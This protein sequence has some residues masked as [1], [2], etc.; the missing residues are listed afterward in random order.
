MSARQTGFLLMEWVMAALMGL[1]LMSTWV[2][3]LQ[4]TQRLTQRVDPV[5][6]ASQQ[7]AWL[8]DRLRQV[9]ARAG[10][11]GIDPWARDAPVGLSRRPDVLWL[12]FLAADAD[13]DCE[14][15]RVVRDAWVVERLF[16]KPATSTQPA[17]LSCDAGRCTPQACTDL[18][19]AGVVWL[20]DVTAWGVRW[21]WQTPAG[22][23]QFKSEVPDPT[24]PQAPQAVRIRWQLETGQ[25]ITQTWDLSHVTP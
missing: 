6:A 9:V 4:F 10:Q 16:L 3:A 5:M 12:Q 18:G 19:D 15:R 13:W 20:D 11:G 7:S 8:S 23:P 22:L 25:P 17:G 24:F 2:M 21:G 1:M 14:G